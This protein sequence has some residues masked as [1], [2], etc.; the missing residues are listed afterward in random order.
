MKLRQL[1]KK[2]LALGLVSFLL[3]PISVDAQAAIKLL[4]VYP[5][6]QAAFTQGLELYGELEDN[7]LL[8]GTGLYGSSSIGLLDLEV[9]EYQVIDNLEEEYFGEGLT[10]TDDAIWQLTWKAGKAFRRNLDTFERLETV[11]YAG[12]GWGLA[13][14]S[15]RQL[16]WMSDGSQLLSIRDQDSFELLGQLEVTYNEQTI[17][18]LNELEYAN[19]LIYANIWLTEQIVAIN[20]ESGEIENVYEL[21]S[22]IALVN[23]EFS[24][25]Q[26]EAM[27]V[28]NGIAHI[29]DNQFFITGKHYPYVLKVEL[30]R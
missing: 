15:D 29:E 13:F 12:Q 23:Q 4:E 25:K 19:G 18:N 17:S 28:L 9:G 2:T 27:D 8:M 6:D 1:I 26:V 24:Q 11:D 3:R 5:S 30:P 22:L 14:D 7:K 21:S 16:L 20:P 10:V